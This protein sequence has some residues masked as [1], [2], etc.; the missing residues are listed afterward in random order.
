MW[1]KERVHLFISENELFDS[2]YYQ[3]LIPF[4]C[5]CSYCC[6]KEI[7][8]PR[9]G[10]FNIFVNFSDDNPKIKKEEINIK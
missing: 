3:I 2:F 9:N 7:N 6:I 5:F 8:N 4:L 10:I 1:L